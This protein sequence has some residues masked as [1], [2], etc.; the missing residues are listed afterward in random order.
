M[1]DTELQHR[2]LVGSLGRDCPMW[3]R[4]KTPNEEKSWNDMENTYQKRK[5]REKKEE[6]LAV[7]LT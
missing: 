7:P 3:K 4:D 6:I 2:P 1:I 5:I